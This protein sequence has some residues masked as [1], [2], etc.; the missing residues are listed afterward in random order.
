MTMGATRAPAAGLSSLKSASLKPATLKLM[1]LKPMSLKSVSLKP[2]S[3]K[4]VSLK[5]VSTKPTFLTLNQA[6][7][8]LT[9]HLGAVVTVKKY[10]PK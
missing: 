9:A 5:P 2:V 10:Y 4:P 1:S 6:A 8:I 7:F 3:L